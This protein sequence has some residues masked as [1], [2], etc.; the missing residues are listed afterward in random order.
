LGCHMIN[1]LR[2]YLGEVSAVKARLG[3][4]FNFDFED[5]ATCIMEFECGASAVVNV[6]WFSQSAAVGVEL[7][8]T[9]AHAR[10]YHSPSNKIATAIKLF[11]GKTPKFYSPHLK[12]ISHFVDCMNVDG[13]ENILSGEDALKDLEVIVKA[14]GYENTM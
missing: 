1:L 7:H 4:R 14:Y 10:A 3:Y 9:I 12:A 8:G 5:H 2:W 11:L 13:K 6:G